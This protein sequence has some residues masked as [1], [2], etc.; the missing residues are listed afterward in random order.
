[1][2]FVKQIPDAVL[3]HL[4]QALAQTDSNRRLLYP[5]IADISG[6]GAMVHPD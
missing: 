3:V 2:R 5:F 6:S 1:M 4:A